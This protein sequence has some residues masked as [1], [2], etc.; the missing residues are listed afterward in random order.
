MRGRDLAIAALFG[1][2]A[3]LFGIAIMRGVA[4][5]EALLARIRLFVSLPLSKL[6]R[7]SLHSRLREIGEA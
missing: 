1:L 2:L 5:C 7:L 6:D 4:L 3:G